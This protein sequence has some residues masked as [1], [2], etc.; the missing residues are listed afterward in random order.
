MQSTAPASFQRS[1]TVSSEFLDAALRLANDPELEKRSATENLKALSDLYDEVHA[2]R[3]VSASLKALEENEQG[4]V[5]FIGGVDFRHVSTRPIIS[6]TSPANA[7]SADAT[8]AG[9]VPS[10]DMDVDSSN[11]NNS[12]KVVEPSQLPCGALHHGHPE[13]CG[14]SQV[15]LTITSKSANGH[16]PTLEYLRRHSASSIV[17]WFLVENFATIDANARNIFTR[18]VTCCIVRADTVVLYVYY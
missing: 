5:R 2:D 17:S 4:S 13:L 16:E 15:K 9:A 11:N 6:G 10:S 3:S 12:V 8:A 7:A 14:G 18:Y 1:N